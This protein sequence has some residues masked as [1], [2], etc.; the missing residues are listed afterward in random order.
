M[1]VMRE[2]D[3]MVTSA[4][5][6]HPRQGDPRK[7]V[8]AWTERD[9]LDGKIVDAYVIILRTPGCHW[10]RESGC[11]MCGYVN[12]TSAAGGQELLHQFGEAMKGYSDEK[13][14]KIFTSGSFFNDGEV[15]RNVQTAILGELAKKTEKIVMETRPEF[16]KKEQLEDLPGRERIEV[17]IGLESAS[18]FVLEHS[19]NKG[20]GAA[21]FV[22]AAEILAGLNIPLKT[23][24][25]IKPPFLTEREAIRDAVS[26]ARFAS[27]Y[28]RTISFNP[29]NVQRYTLVERLWRNR[30]YRPPW[31]WSVV[32]VLRRSCE[33]EDVRVLSSPTGGGT[34]RGAHNCGQCD[35]DVL[36]AIESFSLTQDP[37]VLDIPHCGCRN[38]WSDLLETEGFARTQGDLFRLI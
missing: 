1:I 16:V 31:L 4:R 8:S 30:E 14:V 32:E 24:L 5:S 22:R 15:P 18:D 25:L 27:R 12:D 6:R 36:S 19:V 2:L 38:K 35:K 34:R 26:S 21:D 7:F 28:S 9:V 10:A 23:Y 17:A 37:N 11:S 29:V 33:L 20:F 3:S 13:M